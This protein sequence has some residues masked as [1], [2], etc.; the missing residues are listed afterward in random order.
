[1]FALARTA[2][3]KDQLEISFESL[4][5]RDGGALTDR[6]R[7]TQFL[8]DECVLLDG[9]PEKS[10]RPGGSRHPELFVRGDVIPVKEDLRTGLAPM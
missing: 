5:D 9:H 4:L 8:N 10:K 6:T 7:L 3:P 1:M 2:A